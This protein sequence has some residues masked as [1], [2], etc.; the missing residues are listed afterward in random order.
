MTKYLKEIHYFLNRHPHGYSIYQFLINLGTDIKRVDLIPVSQLNDNEIPMRC[1]I[2]NVKLKKSRCH[3]LLIKLNSEPY[4]HLKLC[5]PD[6]T[7]FLFYFIKL[8]LNEETPDLV[9]YFA[10]IRK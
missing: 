6:I 1:S 10:E 4:I 9:E 7:S 2:T 3:V 5:S 8:Y